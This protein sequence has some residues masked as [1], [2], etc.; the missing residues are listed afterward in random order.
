MQEFFKMLGEW[1]SSN[2]Q[3]ISLAAVMTTVGGGLSYYVV[4]YF[5]PK[6]QNKLLGYVVK[7]VSKMFGMEV[8]GVDDMVKKLPI[9]DKMNDWQASLQSQNELKL[10][11]LKNKIVSPKLSEAER[12]AYQGMFDKIMNDLGDKV[13][14][15]TLKV[16]N[17]ID[18]KAKETIEKI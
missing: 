18:Q 3:G 7:I 14:Y 2:W 1:V 12:V 5:L 9:V 13:S 10:I 16:I 8:E 6:L 15:A 17:E 11:E 4:R